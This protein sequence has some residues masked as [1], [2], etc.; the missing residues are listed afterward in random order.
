MSHG[1]GTFEERLKQNKLRQEEYT[2]R[3]AEYLG[4]EGDTDLE[5]YI[6]T[7]KPTVNDDEGDAD[8][9]DDDDEGGRHEYGGKQY[10][11]INSSIVFYVGTG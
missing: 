6:R 10:G 4:V 11:G 1:G 2:A 8:D 5:P 7:R 9:G 3:I